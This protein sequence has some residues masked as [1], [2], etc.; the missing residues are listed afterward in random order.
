MY[1][2]ARQM[3]TKARQEKHGRHPAILSRWYAQEGYRK[4]LAEHNTWEKE[5]MLYDKIA[6]ERHH[7]TATKAERIQNAKTLCFLFEC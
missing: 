4:S 2:R 1:F 5:I 6:L 7:Y 3:L